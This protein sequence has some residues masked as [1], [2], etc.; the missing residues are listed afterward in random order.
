MAQTEVDPATLSADDFKRAFEQVTVN[1]G[2]MAIL[3][4]HYRAPNKTMTARQLAEATG[5]RS[6]KATNSQYGHL[7]TAICEILGHPVNCPDKI[8]L[9]VQVGDRSE[10]ESECPLVMRPQVAEALEQLGWV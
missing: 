10:K 3:R 2:Q 1:E 4:V 8:L 9:L 5:Y 6:Y 7:A